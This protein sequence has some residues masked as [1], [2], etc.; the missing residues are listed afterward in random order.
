MSTMKLKSLRDRP[1]TLQ[2]EGKRY[3]WPKKGSVMKVPDTIGAWLMGKANDLDR[4]PE[5]RADRTRLKNPSLNWLEVVP[6]EDGEQVETVA[7]IT[8][9]LP[10]DE[11]ADDPKPAAAKPAAAPAK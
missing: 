10:K 5:L 11:P 7:T 2:L 1:F 6:T 8:A 3:A 4:N 9:E